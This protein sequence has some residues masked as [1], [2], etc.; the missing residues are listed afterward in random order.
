LTLVPALIHSLQKQNLNHVL[1][2]VGGVIPPQD[3][4]ALFEA[5]AAAVFGPGTVL[6]VAA[7]QILELMLPA[8]V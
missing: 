4:A 3:Y 7:A 1:V 6:P 2:V 8:T 5:G